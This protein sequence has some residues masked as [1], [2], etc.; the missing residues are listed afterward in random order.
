[1]KKS[2]SEVELRDNSEIN[3]IKL[4]NDLLNNIRPRSHFTDEEPEH[5]RLKKNMNER[6]R[7]EKLSN[8]L[9]KIKVY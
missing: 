6:N 3:E 5:R 7:F 2:S 9:I 4:D 1:M 8:Q